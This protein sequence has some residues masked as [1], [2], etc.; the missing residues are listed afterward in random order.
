MLKT[1]LKTH[2]KYSCADCGYSSTEA[3]QAHM[4]GEN[5]K[6]AP[7]L[8]AMRVRN[9]VDGLANRLKNP[10]S[11]CPGGL[12][13]HKRLALNGSQTDSVAAAS[14]ESSDPFAIPLNAF[15]LNE[16]F[17]PS[18]AKNQPKTYKCHHCDRANL[19]STTNCNEQPVLVPPRLGVEQEGGQRKD[20][21]T[22]AAN[23]VATSNKVS[24]PKTYKWHHCGII[25]LDYIL[26]SMHT[27]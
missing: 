4:N 15:H 25:F 24:L 7:T 14:M 26:Y 5:H 22:V 12:K 17:G 13:A 27:R 6:G 21:R 8:N 10:N 2:K 9:R 11:R 18:Q 20:S 23:R 16:S 3:L 19:N 1:H